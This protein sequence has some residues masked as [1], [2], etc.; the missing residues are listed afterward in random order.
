MSDRKATTV[1]ITVPDLSSQSE[2]DS[3]GYDGEVIHQPDYTVVVP[4]VSDLFDGNTGINARRFLQTAIALADDNDGD[5]VLLGITEVADETTTEQVREYTR[6]D[7]GDEKEQSVPEAVTER[8]TQ[9]AQ[10][11]DVAADIDR[12]VPVQALVRVATDTTQGILAALG[13]GSGTAVLL[14]RGTG[15]EESWLL[16]KSTIDTVIDEAECNVFVE[17]V[18]DREGADALYVP[19]VDG[20]TVASLAESDAEPIESILLPV[21]TG[22]HAALASEA[23]RAVAR[24][25]DAS[26][27]V[28]HVISPDASGKERSDARDLLT[29]AEY[30]LGPEV[31]SE[32]ELREAS[33]PTDVIIEEAQN[34]DFTSIGFPE[35]KFKL[36]NLIFKPLQKTLAGKRDVTVVMGRDADRTMRSLYYRYRRAMENSDTD[37]RSG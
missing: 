13:S 28:L 12:D 8:Q 23:A 16:G 33:D 26:V 30:V 3:Y 22:P 32:T 5:V 14:L 18:G 10:M 27:T 7:D 25:F 11:V 20:H 6:S 17:N 19:D 24:T 2:A 1:P 15:F 36:R 4:V 29:F 31:H 35:Q 37:E 9:L 34:H 21:G